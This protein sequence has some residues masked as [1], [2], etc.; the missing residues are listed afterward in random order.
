MNGG[1]YVPIA[2]SMQSW[3]GSDLACGVWLV[4]FFLRE[5][6]VQGCWTVSVSRKTGLSNLDSCSRANIHKVLKDKEL[7]SS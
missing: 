7:F 1:D 4:E 3:D 6:W 2:L 5:I